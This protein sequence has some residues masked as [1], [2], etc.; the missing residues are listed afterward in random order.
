MNEE[1]LRTFMFATRLKTIEFIQLGEVTMEAWYH[2]DYPPE[3]HG[4]IIY[5][6]PFCLHYFSKK[7]ELE[8]HSERCEV[9]GPPGDEIYRDEK[10]SM[11]EFDA[12]Q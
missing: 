2:A 12:K 7:R 6:C 11:F 3:Y 1:E 5:T 10:V 9:R 8:A 4:R